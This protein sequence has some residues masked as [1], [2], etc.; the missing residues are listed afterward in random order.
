ML[1]A[2]QVVNIRKGQPK[3]FNWKKGGQSVAKGVSK[4]FKGAFGSSQQSQLREE[5][6][7]ETAG[8][9]SLP[10]G[11]APIIGD[12]P[13]T[14]R[15][16]SESRPQG[17]G[18]SAPKDKAGTPVTGGLK[19]GKDAYPSAASPETT[20]F[21]IDLISRCEFERRTVPAIVLRC[22]D[23]VE[24]RGM[25]ME[26]IY[27]KSG[28]FSQVK[29]VQQGFEKDST[30]YDISDPD[31]D[32]HSVTSALKQ[33]LRKLP[34]PL[35]T[36]DSYDGLLEAAQLDGEARISGLRQSINGLPKAHKDTLEVLMLHLVRVIEH[37][38][39]NLMTPL[40][41]S[42]VFAPTIMRPES[43]EREMSDMEI[44]RKAVQ[45]ILQ[46]R[47]EIFPES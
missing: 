11:E 7:A 30:G 21:G 3:K 42:V 45:C 46:H 10:Q 25:D 15:M 26:G 32:I 38:K 20:L 5:H 22:I 44:Q 6:F 4:G 35:I 34:V 1:A 2:P 39:D 12:K 31:L 8:Y 17:W 18:L 36:F 29:Q 27:R 43:L 24:S 47:Q 28:S 41:V 19:P 40:N 37:E 33:Y 23:E 16:G 13:V 14:Q 9:G